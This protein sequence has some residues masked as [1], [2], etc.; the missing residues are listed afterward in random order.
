MNVVSPSMSKHMAA[1]RCDELDASKVSTNWRRTIYRRLTE[2]RY[3]DIWDYYIDGLS[4]PQAKWLIRRGF[5]NA[6]LLMGFVRSLHPQLLSH[7][8]EKGMVTVADQCIA[9]ASE[10]MRQGELQQQR[11]PGWENYTGGTSGLKR[12]YEM[13]RETW[14]LLDH[15][16]C[17]SDYVREE[18]LKEGIAGEKVSVVNYP[19]D[20]T[21]FSFVDRSARRGPMVVGFVGAVCLRKGAPYF[22]EVALRFDPAKV[23]FVMVGPVLLNDS[24]VV[25]NKGPVEVV[26]RAPRAEMG[27]WLEKFDAIFFPSTCEG[28]AYALMEAM[29]TGLPLVTSPNSGTVARHGQ[30]G[31]IAAYDDIEAYSGYLKRLSEDPAMRLEMGRAARR[32][33]EDFQLDRYSRDLGQLFRRLMESKNSDPRANSSR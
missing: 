8:R 7:C 15:I 26:G 24:A 20:E 30:E 22:M 13:E 19:V 27:R 5:G 16:T 29:A 4:Q 3:S 12:A 28:S 1:R 23:R 32:R 2:R 33:Y 25:K 11:W 31:F 18:L 21:L 17:P 14:A 6:N 10:E 9:P